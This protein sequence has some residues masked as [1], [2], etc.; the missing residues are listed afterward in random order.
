M[1]SAECRPSPLRRSCSCLVMSSMLACMAAW[2]TGLT[3][4]PAAPAR[5]VATIGQGLVHVEPN[6]LSPRLIRA[7]RLDAQART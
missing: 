3:P 4:Q 1:S 2:P 6:W 7:M 5:A